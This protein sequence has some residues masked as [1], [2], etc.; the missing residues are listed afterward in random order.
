MFI[1]IDKGVDIVGDIHAC[2]DEWLEMLDRLGYQKNE[3][4]FYVHPKGRKMVSLGDVMSRGP[5]SIETMVFFLKHRHLMYMIDSNH[6]WK[7]A[8]WLDGRK[9]Q[10]KHGDEKVEEEFIEFERKNGKEKTVQLKK[11]LRD[12]LINLP[13]HS[14]LSEKGQPKLV[15]VHAGIR[16]EFIGKESE[17]IKNFCRYGDVAGVDQQGKPIRR[18]WYKQYKGDLLVVWGHD[19]KPEPLMVNNTINIDQGVVF[20]GKLTAYRYPENEFVFVDAKK[21]YAGV[22]DNPLKR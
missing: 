8:R 6:G 12:M 14:I 13:S 17:R 7:I 4:G 18:D 15:C 11:E 2:F 9:V 22:K 19:P 1:N 3:Q 5:K 21:D 10:L 16:E 20:G